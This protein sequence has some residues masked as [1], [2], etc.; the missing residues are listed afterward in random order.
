MYGLEIIE[1]GDG[2]AQQNAVKPIQ[3]P[4]LVLEVIHLGGNPVQRGQVDLKGVGGGD[5]FH[6]KTEAGKRIQGPIREISY[7][8]C[9]IRRFCEARD[10]QAV[11][12]SYCG[13]RCH[14]VAAAKSDPDNI[15]VHALRNQVVVGNAGCYLQG[16]VRIEPSGDDQ[17]MKEGIPVLFQVKI[18]FASGI[19]GKVPVVADVEGYFPGAGLLQDPNLPVEILQAFKLHRPETDLQP[20]QNG[21]VSTDTDVGSPPDARQ[22]VVSSPDGAEAVLEDHFKGVFQVQLVRW[23]VDQEIAFKGRAFRFVDGLFGFCFSFLTGKDQ[24][25]AAQNKKEVV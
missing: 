24:G 9:C 19:D 21:I 1:S 11:V 12:Q 8:P 7:Y 20:V 18:L 3:E 15:V 22:V 10:G 16:E 13:I 4:V 17:L 25:S 2:K 6:A 14:L 23:V 5:E